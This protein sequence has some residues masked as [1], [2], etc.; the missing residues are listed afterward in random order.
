VARAKFHWYPFPGQG[1]QEHANGKSTGRI[2]SGFDTI[3]NIL[4][5]GLE[6]TVSPI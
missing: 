1:K 6:A 4:P 3:D 2:I 5:H